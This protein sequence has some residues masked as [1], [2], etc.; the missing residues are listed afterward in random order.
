MFKTM[1]VV[2]RDVK[3]GDYFFLEME[4]AIECITA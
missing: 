2:M 1:E 3:E 4:G